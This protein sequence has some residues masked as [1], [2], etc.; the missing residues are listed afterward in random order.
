M[1]IIEDGYVMLEKVK[2]IM[3]FLDLLFYINFFVNFFVYSGF[4]K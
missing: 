4:I 3:Y 2:V 1:F